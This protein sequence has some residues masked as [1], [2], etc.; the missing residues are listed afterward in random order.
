MR[1]RVT[2]LAALALCPAALLLAGTQ[3]NAPADQAQGPDI[4][5]EER[6]GVLHIGMPADQIGAALPCQA[7]RGKEV[8]DAAT[9]EYV[10]EWRFPDCGVTIGLG[11][12][13]QGGTQELRAITITR[14]SLLRTLGGIHAGSTEQEVRAAYASMQDT[15]WSEP[16]EHLVAGSIYG[17]MIFELRAGE[18]HSIF[19]GAAAE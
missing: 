14:P 12:D 4:L 3:G 8:F 13:S 10:Q 7:E 2:C 17:G 11:A 19:L 9:G 1:K 16:G 18:V 5:Q 6:I 15:E